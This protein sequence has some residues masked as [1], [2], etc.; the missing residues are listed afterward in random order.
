[1]NPE[2]GDLKNKKRTRLAGWPKPSPEI[3]QLVRSLATDDVR[4]GHASATE[5]LRRQRRANDGGTS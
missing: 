5:I 2:A 3:V 4:R 1:M